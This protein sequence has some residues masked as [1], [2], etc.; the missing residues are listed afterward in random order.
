MR[1]WG[2]TRRGD[3][4]RVSALT[5][6]LSKGW[7]PLTGWCWARRPSARRPDGSRGSLPSARR[8][9]CDRRVRDPAPGAGLDGRTRAPGRG[10]ALADRRVGLVARPAVRR[11][12]R[13]S[14]PAA[15]GRPDRDPGGGRVRRPLLGDRGPSRLEA[16]FDRA[17]A[18]FSQRSVF[19]GTAF[20]WIRTMAPIRRALGTSVALAAIVILGLP[21]LYTLLRSDRPF[22]RLRRSSHG[23]TSASSPRGARRRRHRPNPR[24]CR[25]R[26]SAR[27]AD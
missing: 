14:A 17:S 10:P 23:S 18:C 13:Q 7:S 11:M 1:G 12:L 19:T 27:P 20:L 22:R 3:R 2:R 9:A 16:H 5:A 15:P 25:R 21:L 6:H 24:R 26:R 4:R 8:D